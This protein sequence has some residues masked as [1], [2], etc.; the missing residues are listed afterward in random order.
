MESSN[1]DPTQQAEIK[2]FQPLQYDCSVYETGTQHNVL[3][4]VL[5]QQI[6]RNG[7]LFSSLY[8]TQPIAGSS[9]ST[10]DSWVGSDSKSRDGG[11]ANLD[12]GADGRG[13]DVAFP[14]AH[15]VWSFA[16]FLSS[17]D[18]LRKDMLE[19][20]YPPTAKESNSLK[21]FRSE[22]IK[23]LDHTIAQVNTKNSNVVVYLSG[24]LLESER[25][26]QQLS[27]RVSVLESQI[28]SLVERDRER[29]ISQDHVHAQLSALRSVVETQGLLSSSSS[30]SSVSASSS[31]SFGPDSV[32][33]RLSSMLEQLERDMQHKIVRNLATR[34]ENVIRDLN[35]ANLLSKVRKMEGTEGRFVFSEHVPSS[36]VKDPHVDD[37]PSPTIDPHDAMQESDSYTDSP[38]TDSSYSF[39]SPSSSTDN[40]SPEQGTRYPVG[41]A[42]APSRPPSY[43]VSPYQPNPNAV[44]VSAT[45]E[46]LKRASFFKKF[47]PRER[48]DMDRI[49]I[50]LHT[51]IEGFNRYHE[52]IRRPPGAQDLLQALGDGPQMR[53]KAFFKDGRSVDQAL[54]KLIQL[55]VIQSGVE[56]SDLVQ[57]MYRCRRSKNTTLDTYVF[58]LHAR[59]ELYVLLPDAP[60]FTV[61]MINSMISKSVPQLY[62]PAMKAYTVK[63]TLTFDPAHMVDEL[64]KSTDGGIIRAPPDEAYL[65]EYFPPNPAPHKPNKSPQQPKGSGNGG[66]KNGGQQGKSG[67]GKGGPTKVVCNFCG[68]HGHKVRDCHKARSFNK[69]RACHNCGSRDH[70]KYACPKPARDRDKVPK[71][72]AAVAPVI[73][74]VHP[75]FSVEHQTRSIRT[76]IDAAVAEA[77]SSLASDAD[78]TVAHVHVASVEESLSSDTSPTDE[79]AYRRTKLAKALLG[80]SVPPSISPWNFVT[81]VD[82][83]VHTQLR[84]GSSRVCNALLDTGAV[85]LSYITQEAAQEL[86]VLPM[87]AE[88]RVEALFGGEGAVCQYT[89]QKCTLYGVDPR[90]PDRTRLLSGEI[91]L[92][93]LPKGCGIGSS[94][95][96]V[97]RQDI[98]KAF[99]LTWDSESGAWWGSRSVAVPALDSAAAMLHRSRKVANLVS[100]KR[101]IA[102]AAESG[103]SIKD[104][105]TVDDIDE[106][107]LKQLSDSGLRPVQTSVGISIVGSQMSESE[108][109]TYIKDIEEFESVF[110]PMK[111]PTLKSEPRKI[112]LKADFKPPKVRY[113]SPANPMAVPL[114]K[115][116]IS[117][118]LLRYYQGIV[119]ANSRWF[120]VRKPAYP[121]T[122]VK[123]WRLVTDIS[124]NPGVISDSYP[125]TAPDAI[126]AKLAKF[127]LFFKTDIS[128]AYGQ[129][130]VDEE[131]QKYL[132]L[133]TPIGNLCFPGMPNGLKGSQAYLMKLLG[134]IFKDMVEDQSLWVYV[135]NIQSGADNLPALR[136][137]FRAFLQRC[138]KFGLR[139]NITD[140]W[141][142]VMKL[143][144]LGYRVDGVEHTYSLSPKLRAAVDR[145]PPP[146]TLKEL[147]SVNATLNV[148]RRFVPSYNHVMEPLLSLQR[149][150]ER[151]R[152]PST[153]NFQLS[154]KQLEAFKKAKKFLQS[155]SLADFEPQRETRLYSDFNGFLS[156]GPRPAISATLKQKGPDK[157]WRTV[158]CVSRFLLEGEERIVTKQSAFS[159][160]C[161]ECLAAGYG[162]DK[163]YPLLAQT[164]DFTLMCDSK[165][166]SYFKY[167]VSPLMIR[168]RNLLS[169]RYDLDRI[170]IR[171]IPRDRNAESDMFARLTHEADF[172]D[173]AIALA[174]LP[175][176]RDLST[177][178]AAVR[179]ARHF[180][181]SDFT[182]LELDRMKGKRGFHLDHIVSFHNARTGRVTYVVPNSRREEIFADAHRNP[183]GDVHLSMAQTKHNLSSYTFLTPKFVT[184]AIHD[185]DGC[186]AARTKIREIDLSN[187]PALRPTYFGEIIALDFKGPMFSNSPNSHYATTQEL[188][189]GHLQGLPC[190][191]PSGDSA[192]AS[193]KKFMALGVVPRIVLVD[194]AKAYIVSNDFLAF[195]QSHNIEIVKAKGFN[196]THIASLERSHQEIDCFQRSLD[197]P[198]DWEKHSDD[199][200]LAFNEAPI[201]NGL[202][203]AELAFGTSPARTTEIARRLKT[204]S[205]AV[206]DSEKLAD[207]D[208]MS[209]RK[210]F[211]T[212]MYVTIRNPKS[213]SSKST[214]RGKRYKLISMLGATAL[215]STEKG[216]TYV[217]L[218]RLATPDWSIA[219]DAND[220]DSHVHDEHVQLPA[221]QPRPA[222]PAQPPQPAQRPAANR[223]H[224][225]SMLSDSPQWVLYHWGE[226]RHV[227]MLVPS[228]GMEDNIL[229]HSCRSRQSGEWIPEYVKV[230]KGKAGHELFPRKVPARNMEPATWEVEKNMVI[231]YYPRQPHVYI[232]PNALLSDLAN[233][234]SSVESK[235]KSS[236]LE[237]PNKFDFCLYRAG[238]KLA[239]GMVLIP[240]IVT[241]IQETQIDPV[242]HDYLPVYDNE[243]DVSKAVRNRRLS[244]GLIRVSS[245]IPQSDIIAFCPPASLDSFAL[246][247]SLAE[248]IADIR[249][250]TDARMA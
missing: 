79:D 204:L 53:I 123:G 145:L 96:V 234:A 147:V 63:H 111:G 112:L 9:E 33:E 15:D 78:A 133:G 164:P 188:L 10:D 169:A 217:P 143:D 135:D 74:G 84:L 130:L 46:P 220:S 100:H 21:F 129:V 40:S 76:A 139:L 158:A 183:S 174:A 86:E 162:M 167:S 136:V 210:K 238:N 172:D 175:S 45:E 14:R 2:E 23:V 38:Y 163:L 187:S 47:D 105:A 59:F 55:Y 155:A 230:K 236:D 159:S 138:K 60:S 177:L 195:C 20:K 127:V 209:L 184:R 41:P 244:Q 29:Q 77:L 190:N 39:S 166:L 61:K 81:N 170:K 223:N 245:M 250:D 185:C 207:P 115:H 128:D 99:G 215:I 4:E 27:D 231:G 242:T 8:S 176:K 56:V 171:H 140:T 194:R 153:K 119:K 202:S 131:S 88:L 132:V 197:D 52:H 203:R 151:S 26:R 31:S 240:G 114:L 150:L 116:N 192:I 30:E 137:L 66:K 22:M 193:L 232:P 37:L 43:P 214:W 75:P 35:I 91:K 218:R 18:I 152:A 125:L 148:W 249:R 73:P 165:N 228:Q 186:V 92:H 118:G 120:L 154:S 142:G 11:D 36:G 180:A 121:A 248:R 104:A 113:K 103:R 221:Q 44:H 205:Q 246:P 229:V 235:E 49:L 69:V 179:P 212:G 182:D 6:A 72:A 62:K 68:G 102:A 50:S 109:D 181:P 101:A 117:K 65:L 226:E 134:V 110:Q 1:E 51:F 225:D 216:P 237:K 70:L 199:F 108:V 208:L 93:V 28:V 48:D 32:S 19:L 156:G 64:T 94:D 98:A 243:R 83:S 97:S 5:A 25:S 54:S 239:I 161:G 211:R 124:V 85:G 95:V 146:T 67:N 87:E 178:A 126:V 241:E 122:S 227:G 206:V 106:T 149:E 189:S 160:S 196:P 191:S 200:M 17:F 58:R 34:R 247:A 144:T 157:V 141:Y 12:F 57:F 80:S 233:L 24:L 107:V 198:G 222:L 168:L 71:V 224:Q 90:K 219:H 201:E 16:D 82:G 7:E 89:V 3:C 13:P 213:V 173:K 42:L